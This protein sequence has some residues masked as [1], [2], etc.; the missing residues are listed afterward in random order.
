MM[1]SAQTMGDSDIAGIVLRYMWVHFE[2]RCFS[3]VHQ[4]RR[5]QL[6]LLMKFVFGYEGT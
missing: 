3:T 4:G 5:D 2:T 6:P 1:S